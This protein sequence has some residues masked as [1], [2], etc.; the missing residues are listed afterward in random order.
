MI[1]AKP[2]IYWSLSDGVDTNYNDGVSINS[3]GVISNYT[4][5]TRV[6]TK[7]LL[8]MLMNSLTAVKHTLMFDRC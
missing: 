4:E 7:N 5:N 3:R 2:G 1:N 8:F 6:I